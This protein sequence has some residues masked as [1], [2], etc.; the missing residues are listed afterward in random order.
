[1]GMAITTNPWEVK[2]TSVFLDKGFNVMIEIAP[3]YLLAS[4]VDYRYPCTINFWGLI[5][6]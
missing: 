6:R 3:S 4:F 1:M 5:I 2:T